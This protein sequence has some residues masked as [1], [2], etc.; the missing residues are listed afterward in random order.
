M[1]IAAM[2]MAKHLSNKSIRRD[3]KSIKVNIRAPVSYMPE[4][5]TIP[6]FRSI[7]QTVVLHF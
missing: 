7:T 2:Q 3:L 1:M 5:I 6:L 4:S